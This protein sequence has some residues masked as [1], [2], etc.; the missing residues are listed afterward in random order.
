MKEEVQE[1]KRHRS[2]ELVLPQQKFQLEKKP[3]KN[4]RNIARLR[5]RNM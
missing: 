3:L 1:Q 2:E 4:M 5:M